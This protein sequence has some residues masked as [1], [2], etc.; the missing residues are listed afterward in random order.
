MLYKFM[1]KNNVSFRAFARNKTKD[2]NGNEGAKK[3]SHM[4]EAT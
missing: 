4:P 2:E 3:I 1:V